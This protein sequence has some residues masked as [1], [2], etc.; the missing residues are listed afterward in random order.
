MKFRSPGAL[1]KWVLGSIGNDGICR[2]IRDGDDRS[3]YAE[4]G[5]CLCDGREYREF[6]GRVDGKIAERPRG[7]TDFGW[8]PVFE[9]EG[10]GVTFAEMTPDEKNAISMRARAFA[11][12]R[13][14]LDANAP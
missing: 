10:R 6:F 5:L 2:L 4:T 7:A 12:L 8:D 11:K 13:E 9:P 1:V 14:Y 3:A